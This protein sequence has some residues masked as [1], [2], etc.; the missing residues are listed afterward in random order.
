M[1]AAY[2]PHWSTALAVGAFAIIYMVILARRTSRGRLD[3]YEFAALSTIA[4][5]PAMFVFFPRLADEVAAITGV[6]FP[7]VVM[8][9]ALFVIVFVMLH[10]LT[11][12]MHRQCTQSV[13]L[14]QELSLLM[15]KL[16][17]TQDQLRARREPR[18]GI[19]YGAANAA[20]AESD[21]PSTKI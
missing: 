20:L 3:I 6:A 5:I 19:G 14:I 4:L 18:G 11:F 8:F 1:G 10:R 15:H 12:Q 13:K 21:T 9:G 16:D 7:F 17:Q 2:E